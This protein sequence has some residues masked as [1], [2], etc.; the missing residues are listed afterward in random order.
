MKQ[1]RFE[2]TSGEAI[3]PKMTTVPAT[4]HINEI[5]TAAMGTTLAASHSRD[6][7]ECYQSNH[8]CC[9]LHFM[10]R[11]GLWSAYLQIFVPV[12]LVHVTM[13]MLGTQVASTRFTL[14][15]HPVL[16]NLCEF[17]CLHWHL[18]GNVAAGEHRLQRTPHHLDLQPDRSNVGSTTGNR[19]SN[20]FTC[21]LRY[22]KP[23][24]IFEKL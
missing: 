6:G 20:A 18:L 10:N 11:S 23:R 12:Q 5:I 9:C 24:D 13:F 4:Q 21:L 15:A 3:E 2:L 19:F 16:V 7:K 22:R 8:C 17:L 14:L 1:P